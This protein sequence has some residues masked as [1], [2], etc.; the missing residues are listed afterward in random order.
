MIQYKCLKS[1]CFLQEG[2]IKQME[3]YKTAIYCR[4][5]QDDG[6]EGDSSS[7]QTQKMMLKQYAQDNGF[8]I[9]DIYVDD[10]Y[11]GL[12][13]ERPAF[14]R[15]LQDIEKGKVNLVITKDLS[16]LGR[17]YIM[18][19]YYTEIYFSNMNVRYIAVTDGIDT[20]KGDND[21][22]PFKNILNDMYAK[23]IS[24]KIKSAKRQRMYKGMYIASQP[25]Y[26]YKVNPLNKNQLI[27]DEEA[28]EVVK[29]I[30]RLAL[31]N[32][33]VVKIVRELNKR[34]IKAPSCYKADAGDIRFLKLVE[35]RRQLY[36][37]YDVETWNTAT[38]G[39]ILRDIVYLGDMENHKYEV[40]N[41]K[42]KKR[43]RVPDDEHIIV[44]NTHE[45][46]I[47]REDFEKVQELIKSR[48][49]PCKYEFINLFKGI[50]KC[51]HCGRTL[52]IAY[53]KRR[54]GQKVYEFRCMGKYLKYGID[55]NLNSI[56][57]Q[58]IYDIVNERLHKLFD[59][60]KNQGDAFVNSISK[61]VNSENYIDKLK[62]EKEKI[63]KR[64]SVISKIVK[65]LYEDFVA[66]ELS[67]NNYQS[68]L[69]EYQKEQKELNL[70]LTEIDAKLIK[71]SNN[72]EENAL[73][74]KAI[75]ENYLD[76]QELSLELINNLIDHIVVGYPKIVDGEEVRNIEI[77]YR[78]LN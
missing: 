32:I 31:T 64:I 23:D 22:A 19:G 7:I 69:T 14:Q 49:R 73:R 40:K 60:I 5:S 28:A 57:Y 43:T 17:D 45:A 10:G 36:K 16:R 59:T 27:V 50:L 53:H 67:G 21:I 34:G 74:F 12:N 51:E 47:D 75:A 56:P 1:I 15:M 3:L 41:Y 63:E 35:T 25:P 20:L 33:G 48:Q 54:N 70:R 72:R 62:R 26:G 2:Q 46:I 4:L 71:N 30:Y 24:R 8:V 77:V 52:S 37:N 13:F 78:F 76:F 42:T 18:T 44:R 66:D 29:E 65:K 11:S 6:Q 55:T 9:H 38:V 39:K 58:K 61:K 68:M